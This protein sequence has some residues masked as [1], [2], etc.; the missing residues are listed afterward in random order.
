MEEARE[1]GLIKEADTAFVGNGVNLRKYTND[2]SR[3]RTRQEMGI[4]PEDTLICWVGRLDQQKGLDVLLEAFS[5]LKHNRSVQL[6]LAGDGPLLAHLRE[7]ARRFGMINRVHF[8]GFRKDI[9]QLLQAADIFVLPSRY[10]AMPLSI[11]EAMAV[12]LPC[13]VSDTGENAVM[14]ENNVNG[15]IVPVED[16]K[17]L[18]DAME[19]LV[20]EPERCRA[21]GYAS[22]EKASGYSN[23][24][25]VRRIQQ[26]YEIV[27]RTASKSTVKQ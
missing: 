12:G 14:V 16:V 27:S 18:A 20:N 6:Y 11:I 8:L 24:I 19:F 15:L 26:I 22:L 4:Q 10:E 21:M 23:E 25:T 9:P 1:M 3:L 7:Q 5:W 17:A 2:G 13:I